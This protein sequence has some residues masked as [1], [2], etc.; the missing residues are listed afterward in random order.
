MSER[1][2]GE[3]AAATTTDDED[4]QALRPPRMG[5]NDHQVGRSDR[6]V[7]RSVGD[8]VVREK[9]FWRPWRPHIMQYKRSSRQQAARRQAAVAAADISNKKCAAVALDTQFLTFLLK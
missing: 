9:F 7:G 6:S 2:E 5:R 8:E 4:D 3:L 1:L